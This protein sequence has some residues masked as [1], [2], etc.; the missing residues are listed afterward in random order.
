MESV[1]KKLLTITTCAV[2]LAFGSVA[3]AQTATTPS[4][5]TTTGG[6][7]MSQVSSDQ[8][9]LA[10]WSV[11]ENIIG[12]DVYNEMDEKVG[13]VR[14]LILNNEGRATHY[15][16]GVGGFLGLAEHDVAI[17]FDQLQSGPDRFMLRGYTKDQLKELPKAKIN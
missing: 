5:T 6:T 12:K 3:F 11:K 7:T 13:D 9:H 4:T 1:M 10:G 15:V 8:Q 14:D 2:S 17:P 16:V